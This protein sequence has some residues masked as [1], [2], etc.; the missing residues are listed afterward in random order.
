VGIIATESSAGEPF[1]P[2]SAASRWI[3]VLPM[4]TA[5]AV[6][7]PVVRSAFVYDEFIHLYNLVNFGPLELLLTPHGGQPLFFSNLS[8]WAIH[9]IFG[10]RESAY[11]SVALATHL[12]NVGLCH[13]VIARLTGRPL[14]AGLASTMWGCAA[15]NEGAVGW[16]AAYGEVI[17][18]TLLLVM[19]LDV[20]RLARRGALPSLATWGR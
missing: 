10:M 3:V 5:L 16:F 9:S 4:L 1:G 11:Y 8:Y 6:F 17:L 12:C 14:L 2:P 19:L 13:G 20:A 7:A 18:T 15:I